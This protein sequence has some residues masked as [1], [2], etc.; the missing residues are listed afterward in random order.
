MWRLV[1]QSLQAVDSA[2]GVEPELTLGLSD[3]QIR[4]AGSRGEQEQAG[5]R[6]EKSGPMRTN[7]PTSVSYRVQPQCC[8]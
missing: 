2:S 3:Q 6:E 8:G 1:E 7:T 4:K 5:V